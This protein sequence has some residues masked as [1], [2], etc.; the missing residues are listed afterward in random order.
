MGRK[1]R[2]LIGIAVGLIAV[3]WF[4]HDVDWADLSATLGRVRLGWVAAA[5]LI[6]LCESVIRAVRWTV[7]LRPLGTRAN[8]TDLFSATV[9]GAAMNTL[10]PLR[11]GD[12]AKALVA[13]R[14][15]GY[16]LSAVA[17]TWV[18]ERVY[19]ILGM[20]SVLALMVIVLPAGAAA[21]GELVYNLKLYGGFF[22]FGA[23]AAMA[24]FFALATRPTAA[25]GGFE[26]IVSIAPRP[27]A[28][29]FL[30]LFDGFVAGLGNSRDLRGLAQAGALSVGLWV[31]LA[32]A[33]WC[34]FRAFDM[35]LP[36]GAA[37]FT[38]VAV[39]LSVVLPQAPGFIGVFHVAMEKT[40]LLWG[41]PAASAQGFAIVFWAVSFLPVTA[42]GLI[43]TWREGLSVSALQRGA[44]SSRPEPGLESAGS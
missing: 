35:A 27:I 3:A 5:A 39:A 34:L 28:D 38:G 1:L 9:I 14:R 33:I 26:R 32:G 43:A 11:A 20:S 36:F 31:S 13:S 6:I 8:V 18:M 24:V 25:R 10:L 42:V 37:C 22:G 16:P 40:M 2:L 7:L 21:E 23:L 30:M 12:V 44:V 15:T 19:D 17:A 29:R 4:A 41:Q